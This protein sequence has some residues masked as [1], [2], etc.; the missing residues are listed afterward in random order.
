MIIYIYNTIQYKNKYLS[1]SK[2]KK[3]NWHKT[4]V[5]TG[6]KL[7]FKAWPAGFAAA[8]ESENSCLP[9]WSI[10][11]GEWRASAHCTTAHLQG[12]HK[13]NTHTLT[14]GF[15]VGGETHI[16]LRHGP[17][18]LHGPCLIVQ[19]FIYSSRERSAGELLDEPWPRGVCCA[20]FTR[21]ACFSLHITVQTSSKTLRWRT[22]RNQR[23][24]SWQ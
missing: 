3:H 22:L 1:N 9:E 21:R 20:L 14:H 13:H 16:L 17:D 15:T 8:S 18:G 4:T 2:C 10:S 23:I 5:F 6:M 11:R 24:S 7:Q 19:C 12:H